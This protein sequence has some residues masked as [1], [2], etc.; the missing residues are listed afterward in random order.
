MNLM[1][2]AQPDRCAILEGRFHP[3]SDGS[4]NRFSFDLG[5]SPAS[6]T[7]LAILLRCLCYD[8]VGVRLVIL[9]LLLC[10]QVY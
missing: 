7:G 4:H 1:T 6:G 2:G 3:V 8:T 9:A 10:H 5:S